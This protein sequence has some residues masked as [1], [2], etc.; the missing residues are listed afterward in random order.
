MK[1]I[2]RFSNRKKTA[3]DTVD[4]DGDETLHT[5]VPYLNEAVVPRTAD[6]TEYYFGPNDTLI[7]KLGEQSLAVPR[8]TTLHLG[9]GH[10]V[11]GPSID[12]TPFDG[13]EMGV[14]RRHA[15]IFYASD[16]D[17]LEVMDLGSSNGTFIN[18]YFL[19]PLQRYK[20]YDGDVINLGSLKLEV[21]FTRT[22]H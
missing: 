9:R 19:D 17:C 16:H 3:Q 10:H 12:F 14:S 13:T 8:L 18:G 2:G 11:E 22:H 5:K 6:H 4:A 1:L 15:Q 20:L 21:K 7:L